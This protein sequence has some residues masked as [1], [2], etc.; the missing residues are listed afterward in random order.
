MNSEQIINLKRLGRRWF[1]DLGGNLLHSLEVACL[2]A[3]TTP[4]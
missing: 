3:V 2:V 4:R 1:F